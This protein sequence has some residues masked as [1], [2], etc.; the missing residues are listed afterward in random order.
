M[1][2]KGGFE[3]HLYDADL[4]EALEKGYDD[5]KIS[6]KIVKT[7]IYM[8]LWLRKIFAEIKESFDLPLYL[9]MSRTIRLGSSILQREYEDRIKEIRV[10]WRELR[11]GD[12]LWIEALPDY[13][14]S[15]NNMRAPKKKFIQLPKWCNDML[16]DVTTQLNIDKGAIIRLTMYFALAR[17]NKLPAGIKKQIDTEIEKFDKQIKHQYR[18]LKKLT[19]AGE[20]EE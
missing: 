5:E 20:E 14:Y 16:T 10:L 9:I 19:E 7:T 12:D 15:I 3:I 8:P 13:K 17:W 1:N 2:K 11:W 6:D 4:K 18:D